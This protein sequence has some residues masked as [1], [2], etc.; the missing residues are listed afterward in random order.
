MSLLATLRPKKGSTK[1]RK[2]LGRG[3]GS[4]LGGTSGKGH[5]GQKARSGGK[6]R[7]GFEG[8]QMPLARRNPKFGFSNA[9]F[10]TRYQVINLTQ[11]DEFKGDEVN[12][13]TL[14]AA[15]LIKKGSLVK[16]LGNGEL[17]KALKVKVHKAS[18]SAK[19]AIESA[20]GSIE[21]LAVKEANKAVETS[22]KDQ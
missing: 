4:G 20:G 13:K 16:V 12:P 18:G 10:T 21:F 15:G 6:V 2:V 11:L 22:N 9:Q 1:R 8:G 7:W 14:R 17:K 19:S 3:D 5:K